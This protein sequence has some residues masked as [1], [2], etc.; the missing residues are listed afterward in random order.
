MFNKLIVQ[1]I[2]NLLIMLYGLIGDFGLAII[3]FTIIVKTVLIPL[4]KS[5]HRQTK[6]LRQIQPEIAKI[7]KKTVGNRQAEMLL[8][9]SLHRANGIK[10]S[11]SFLSLIIQLPIMIAIFQVVRRI[12]ENK[13]AIAQYSYSFVQKFD[14]IKQIIDGQATFKPT[15]F[16]LDLTQA[17]LALANWSS[18]I[19]VG[20]LIGQVFL[21]RKIMELRT[22]TPTDE[23]GQKRRFRDVMREAQDGKEHDQ[24]ELSQIT[25]NNMTKI[26]PFMIVPIL[27]FSYGAVS[28]YYFFSNLCDFI[29][30]KIF[31]RED[32]GEVKS[33]ESQEVSERLK[34]A[35]TAQIINEQ[36]MQ[37]LKNR[38][39]K[40]ESSGVRV[41]R[42]KAKKK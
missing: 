30:I 21:Q 20:F 5:Q 2:F 32:L 33:I 8:T 1:P 37:E 42:I 31:D 23:K 24:A 28:F 15:L 6:K 3:V 17:P 12:V 7:K 9:S 35:Q 29:Q 4:A 13:D 40:T 19:L 39:K 22:P 26:M 16:G 18:V 36:R 10:A 11:T 41:T 38:A 34:K 27:G 14:R 25:N